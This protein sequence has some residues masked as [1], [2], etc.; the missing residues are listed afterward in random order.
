MTAIVFGGRS[1]LAIETAKLLAANG[2]AVGLVTRQR[3]TGLTDQLA[4]SPTITIIEADLAR[5]GDGPA[6]LDEFERRS[7]TA[8]GL[9]FLQRFRGQASDAAQQFQVEVLATYEVIGRFCA[10]Q[11][12]KPRSIVIA[13]SPASTAVVGDQPFPYHASKA[14]LDQLTRWSAYHYGPLGVRVNAIR[15]SS[16]ILKDR[17]KAHYEDHPELVDMYERIIPLRRMGR[18][19]DIAEV[20]AFLLSDAC[21][22]L[23]GQVITIDGG[24]SLMDAAG[25]ARTASGI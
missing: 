20:V 8:T 16:I 12:R 19:R 9:V 1:P 21:D 18:P 13:T 11:P 23:T 7:G 10:D 17:A 5:P 24:V 14:A 4:D 2:K 3:D 6:A 22:Y 15:P 25:I